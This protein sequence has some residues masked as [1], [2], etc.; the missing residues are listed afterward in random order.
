VAIVAFSVTCS[1]LAGNFWSI[2]S[3]PLTAPRI[4][5]VYPVVAVGAAAMLLGVLSS[6]KMLSKSVLVY[7]GKISYGLYVYHVLGLMVSDYMVPQADALLGRYLLR[8]AIA[9]TLTI[10]F[11]A[12]SF[13]WVESPFLGIKQRF[14][15]VLSRPGG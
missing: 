7:L 5:A 9:L 11:A 6:A 8:D 3:D 4:L 15:H 10:T 13:R 12:A 2:K 14:T 1:A